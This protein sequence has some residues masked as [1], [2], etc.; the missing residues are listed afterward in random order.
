MSSGRRLADFLGLRRNLVIL[1]VAT[2]VI[3]TGEE[4]WVRPFFG[5][6]HLRTQRGFYAYRM[7]DGTMRWIEQQRQDQ[8]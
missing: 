1:L 2:F 8:K 3:G 5:W 6:W 4:L 7:R